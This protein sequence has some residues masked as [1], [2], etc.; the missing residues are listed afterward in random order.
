M[1]LGKW[2]LEP[3]K[4]SPFLRWA[5]WYF[6]RRGLVSRAGL[7]AG[8]WEQGGAASKPKS[9]VLV[10]CPLDAGHRDHASMLTNHQNAAA[11]SPVRGISGLLSQP[12]YLP[13]RVRILSKQLWDRPSSPC[14]IEAP[15]TVGLFWCVC[16]LPDLAYFLPGW[17]KRERESSWLMELL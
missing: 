10:G 14:D 4:L 11:R 15:H 12:L 8:I 6:S 5:Q 17:G 7:G 16:G 13:K 3:M 9:S 1:L 2:F